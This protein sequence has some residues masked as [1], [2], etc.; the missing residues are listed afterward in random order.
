M[1]AMVAG[2]LLIGALLD[3]QLNQGAVLHSGVGY[4][5]ALAQQISHQTGGLMPTGST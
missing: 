4:V 2:L 5:A 1:K 3:L